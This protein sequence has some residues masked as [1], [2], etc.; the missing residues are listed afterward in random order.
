MPHLHNHA[1]PDDFDRAFKVGI[2]LNGIYVLVEAGFGIAYNS[3]ALLSDAGHN[4][5]DILALVLAWGA[6]WLSRSQPT[7]R[8]TYGFK[9]ATVLA[10]LSS[11]LLLCMALGIIIWE[12]IQRL[13]EP[14]MV[15]GLVIMLAAG[16][17]V[18]INGPDFVRVRHD[19]QQPSQ[20]ARVKIIVMH[21]LLKRRPL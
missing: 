5:S 12:S 13:S 15:N 3:V 21:P 2:A 7:E 10:S 4:L 8:R 9:R 14:L 11:A 17:G 1:V 6:L 16:I 19:I 18:F 20:H